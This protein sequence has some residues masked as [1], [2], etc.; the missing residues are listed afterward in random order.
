MNK[1]MIV[2]SAL[3]L[4]VIGILLLSLRSSG[5][6]P[7][8]TK[9][10]SEKVAGGSFWKEIAALSKN[11]RM[12]EIPVYYHPTKRDPMQPVFTYAEAGPSFKL[13]IKGGASASLTGILLGNGKATAII[14]EKIFRVGDIVEGKKIIAI[15]KNRVI[16]K[17]GMDEEILRLGT[18]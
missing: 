5:K 18:N 11:P 14:N 7:A 2:L 15:E 13:M 6:P 12:L 3:V 8:Q 4:L 16:L 1:R 10:E 17:K 9:K